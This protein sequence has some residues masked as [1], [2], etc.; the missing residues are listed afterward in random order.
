MKTI[1]ILCEAGY[2][3]LGD[4]LSLAIINRLIRNAFGYDLEP[5]PVTMDQASAGILPTYN[6]LALI[7]P[8]TLLA[9]NTGQWNELLARQADRGWV[10][11][12]MG[13]GVAHP[14]DFGTSKQGQLVLGRMLH[15]SPFLWLRTPDCL[16]AVEEAIELFCFK[17]D[18]DPHPSPTKVVGDPIHLF[19]DSTFPEDAEIEDTDQVLINFGYTAHSRGNWSQIRENLETFCHILKDEGHQPVAWPIWKTHDVW[20]LKTI[21]TNTK[22][23]YPKPQAKIQDI[24][25]TVLK[26]KAAVTFRLHAGL[27]AL[28]CGIP[29]LMIAYQGKILSTCRSLSW[30]YVVDPSKPNL[31]ETMAKMFPK[32]LDDTEALETVHKSIETKKTNANNG[33]RN[34]LGSL[35]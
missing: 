35:R 31:A 33:L 22:I 32:M 25:E 23:P 26:S 11:G 17:E 6:G 3:N 8:G 14:S 10:L 24:E 1:P 7:G 13:T 34:V 5:W 4:D 28:A 19:F 30:P 9:P 21:A 16:K 18:K 29:A 2:G 27:F 15:N 12:C 20:P